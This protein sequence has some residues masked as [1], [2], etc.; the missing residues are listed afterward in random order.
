MKIIGG[1]PA[2]TG[3]GEF[4][5]QMLRAFASRAFAVIAWSGYAR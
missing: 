4:V 2:V 5:A 1:L 3:L